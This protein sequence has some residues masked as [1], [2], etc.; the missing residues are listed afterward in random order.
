MLER[1]ASQCRRCV[2]IWWLPEPERSGLVPL[3]S[4]CSCALHWTPNVQPWCFTAW[5][6]WKG[7]GG[8]RGLGE[9][10]EGMGEGGQLSKAGS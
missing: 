9:G 7:R 6:E 1:G 3:L 2:D 4:A 8:G 5:R 10:V